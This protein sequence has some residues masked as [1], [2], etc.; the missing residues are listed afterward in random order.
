MI[1]LT[2]QSEV[3]LIIMHSLTVPADKEIILTT[4]PVKTLQNWIFQKIA[5]LKTYGISESRMIFDVGLGF[6]KNAVQCRELVINAPEM[7]IFCHNLGVRLL[8]GHSRKSFMNLPLEQRDVETAEITRYL[9]MANVDFVRVHNAAI[10]K[11]A[12][13]GGDLLQT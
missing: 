3:E 8:Y 5:S 6:G 9:A 1:K 13:T 12:I 2:A 11:T 10:N 7:A 4:P